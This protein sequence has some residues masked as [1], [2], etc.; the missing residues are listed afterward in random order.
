VGFIW[1][2]SYLG[3]R[4][5]LPFMGDAVWLIVIYSSKSDELRNTFILL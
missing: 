1:R 2:D 4:E 3:L 5:T